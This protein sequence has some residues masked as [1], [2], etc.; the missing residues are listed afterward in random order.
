MKKLLAIILILLSILM[1]F[2]LFFSIPFWFKSPDGMSNPN[3]EFVVNS[4]IALKFLQMLSFIIFSFYGTSVL[5]NVKRSYAANLWLYIGAFA[6][7]TY[8]LEYA[9][10][11]MPLVPIEGFVDTTSFSSRFFEAIIYQGNVVKLLIYATFF[12]LYS[13][14]KK[15]AIS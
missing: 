7:I 8:I 2:Q 5:L 11:S 9:A 14:F 13:K 6:V 15:E 10:W 1:A 3:T 12:G 4:I